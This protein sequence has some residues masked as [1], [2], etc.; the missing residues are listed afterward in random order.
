[1]IG[2]LSV[3]HTIAATGHV[4]A[5]KYTQAARSTMKGCLTPCAGNQARLY[6]R[7]VAAIATA[8]LATLNRTLTRFGLLFERHTHC[9]M[10]PVHA[11]T[12]LSERLRVVTEIST[13]KKFADIVPVIPGKLTLNPEAKLAITK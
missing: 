8:I 4:F 6:Q 12:R 13:K 2:L 11:I 1:M 10:V 7:D 3:R 9:R 5:T